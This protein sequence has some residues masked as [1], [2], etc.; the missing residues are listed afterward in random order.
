MEEGVN[1]LLIKFAD[2]TKT[3]AVA[4]SEEQMELA[5][6]EKCEFLPFLSPRKVILKGRKIVAMEFVRTEQDEDGNWNEDQDQVFRLKANVV[7]SAFG[8][9]LS[10][11]KGKDSESES[12]IAEDQMD[13]LA[14]L[15]ERRANDHKRVDV[16]LDLGVRGASEQHWI[17]NAEL[18]LS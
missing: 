3:E 13:V 15:I 16:Q 12:V 5:K 18:H 1:S 8:S 2:D 10:D 9:I 7:I 17:S 14:N 11:P 4:T 6:E